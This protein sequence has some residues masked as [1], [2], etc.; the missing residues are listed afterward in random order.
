MGHGACGTEHPLLVFPVCPGSVLP[1]GRQAVWISCEIKILLQWPGAG[2]H[3]SQLVLTLP[4]RTHREKPGLRKAMPIR[5]TLSNILGKEKQQ[6]NTANCFPQTWLSKRGP[7]C[8]ISQT[9]VVL[10]PPSLFKLNFL[11]GNNCRF[12]CS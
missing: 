7:V 3:S 9:P 8:G 2:L 4:I 5:L 11:F 10:E 6:L 12:L 1:P